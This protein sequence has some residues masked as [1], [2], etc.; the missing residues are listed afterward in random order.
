M[1]H[2]PRS[3]SLLRVWPFACLAVV[4]CAESPDS[5]GEP[6]AWPLEGRLETIV[7]EGP[8]GATQ[9]FPG[10]GRRLR[11][12]RARFRRGP[13]RGLGRAHRRP[14]PATKARGFVSRRSTTRLLRP[15]GRD[16]D[17]PRRSRRVS[18]RE[19]RTIAFV[20][21][22]YGEGVNVTEAAAQR[23]MF[24]TTQPGPTLGIGANDKST[25]QFYDETSFGFFGVSGD[26]EGPLQWTGAAGV[27]R[28]RREPAREA[29]SARWSRRRTVTTSGTTAPCSRR[30]NTAGAASGTGPRRRATS[31]STATLFDGAITHEIGHNLGYQHASSIRCSGTP[32]ANDPLTCT[33]TEYGS[34]IS[35]MGN[36][37]NGHMMALEKWYAG[38]FKGCNAV[39]VRSSGT[40]NLLPIETR[41]RRRPGAADPDAGHDA[42]VRSAA[43]EH[44][45]RSATTTSSTGTARGLDTGMTPAVY[46]VASDDIAA[47]NR[48]CARSVQMDMNPSTNALNGMTA[49]QSFTDPAGGVMFSVTSLN[50]ASAV[51]NVTLSAA[52]MPNTCMDGSELAGSGPATCGGG[53]GGSG[54][55]ERHGGSGRQARADAAARRERRGAG[56]RGGATGTGGARR[57][58]RRHDGNG[59]RG[60]DA[61]ARPERRGTIGTGG[62]PA[63]RADAAARRDAGGGAWAARRGAQPDAAAPVAA[64]RAVPLAR[65]APESDGRQHRRG[66]RD[67]SGR[68]G[69]HSGRRRRCHRR[70]RPGSDRRGLR[71]RGRRIAAQP[72]PRPGDSLALAGVVCSRRRRR[73]LRLAALSRS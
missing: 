64:R 56:G 7:F 24:S 8:Q 28:L 34:A 43:D 47:P 20:M 13:D 50:A 38:W 16:R 39:R 58:T 4:A 9:A 12:D 48:V 68:P 2:R 54:G 25:L 65:P 15:G 32:L 71:L 49:G 19:M 51:I 59:R 53:T 41:V 72:H 66:W 10:A 29:C 44:R 23:F 33:T 30:A 22:D 69:R 5:T 6:G 14:R 63:Q 1:R 45:P 61:A 52:A 37:S 42:A 31:G 40:F 62:A 70:Q 55:G 57:R 36:T 60:L 18:T 35:I 67:R 3:R 46:V 27:Q 73:S 11:G 17:A 26:V 21:V